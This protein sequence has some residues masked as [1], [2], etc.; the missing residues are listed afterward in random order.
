MHELVH[1]DHQ[2]QKDSWFNGY[3]D[4]KGMRVEGLKDNKTTAVEI[5][6]KETKYYTGCPEAFKR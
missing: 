3:Y 2:G 4:N 6:I 1:V 5:A